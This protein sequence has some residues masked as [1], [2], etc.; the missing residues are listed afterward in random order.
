MLSLVIILA[1]VPLVLL[2]SILYNTASIESSEEQASVAEEINR[3]VMTI[4]SISESSLQ[5]SEQ[6]AQASEEL[7]KLG[8]K[9][10]QLSAQFNA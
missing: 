2:S 6:V 10:K 7:L 3:N 5:G 1:L 4:S 9:L 8:E